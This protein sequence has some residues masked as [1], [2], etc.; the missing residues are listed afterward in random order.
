MEGK[1]NRQRNFI[2]FRLED[3]EYKS[4]E[5]SCVEYRRSVSEL[6]RELK[7]VDVEPINEFRLKGN[8]EHNARIRPVKVVFKS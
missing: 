2:I 6:L 4:G 8:A 1:A 5:D 7:I 3:N